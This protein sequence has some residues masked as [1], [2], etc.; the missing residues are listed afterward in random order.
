MERGIPGPAH[1]VRGAHRPGGACRG[2]VE[3]GRREE[4]AMIARVTRITGATNAPEAAGSSIRYEREKVVPILKQ[5]QGFRGL[6]FLVDRQVGKTL[7][8]ALWETEADMR[9]N[10]ADAAK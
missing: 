1:R 6:Y 10:I 8:I 9:A 2:H 7:V 4:S 5:K 3:Q